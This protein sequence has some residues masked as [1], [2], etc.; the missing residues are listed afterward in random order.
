LKSENLEIKIEICGNLRVILGG[1][2]V[3]EVKMGLG[4]LNCGVWAK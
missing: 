1:M 2:L 3:F 4:K